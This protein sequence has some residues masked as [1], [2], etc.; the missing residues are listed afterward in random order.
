MSPRTQVLILGFQEPGVG[1]H[2]CAP[3]GVP[4][5]VLCWPPARY[6][7][8]GSP[9]SPLLTVLP[10]VPANLGLRGRPEGQRLASLT[11]PPSFHWRRFPSYQNAW[12]KSRPT[13]LPQLPKLQFA[14][15]YFGMSER[16]RGYDVLPRSLWRKA[17]WRDQHLERQGA[18]KSTPT[19][20]KFW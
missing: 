7:R 11:F 8:A 1:E 15:S 14:Q 9:A 17:L 10:Q 5:P 3:R 6:R 13:L 18:R 12:D 4:D 16:S 20:N 2:Q 19:K